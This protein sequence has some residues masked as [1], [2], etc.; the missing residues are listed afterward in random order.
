MGMTSRQSYVGKDASPDSEKPVDMR[1]T[2][3]KK[4]LPNGINENWIK[5]FLVVQFFANLF[6]NIDMGILPA[7][8]TKIKQELNIENTRFGFLGSVVYLG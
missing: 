8:S 4:K 3:E 5:I 7:G 2:F 1:M 6:V